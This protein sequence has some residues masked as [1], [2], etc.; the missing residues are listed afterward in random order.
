MLIFRF[1]FPMENGYEIAKVEKMYSLDIVLQLN[2]N[3]TATY[4]YY[5]IIVNRDAILSV[6]K[7]ADH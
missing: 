5:R 6:E 4:S 2:M 1:P 3:E 7:I